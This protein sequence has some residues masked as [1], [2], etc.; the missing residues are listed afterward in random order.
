MNAALDRAATDPEVLSI[1][2]TGVGRAFCAGADLRYIATLPDEERRP[3]TARFVKAF[4]DIARRI[5][6]FPSQPSQR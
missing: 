4:S 1:V 6:L 3:A 2:I 5:E